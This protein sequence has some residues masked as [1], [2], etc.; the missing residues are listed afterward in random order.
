[1]K[2]KTLRDFG[3]EYLDGKTI[4]AK[5]FKQKIRAE[6]VKWVKYLN[7]DFINRNK[8]FELSLFMGF[9][10]LTKADLEEKSE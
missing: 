1:M 10:N 2:L 7:S 4:D 8:M 5:T 6:A 3:T 9:F